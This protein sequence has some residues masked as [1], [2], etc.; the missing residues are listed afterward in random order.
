MNNGAA[1]TLIPAHVVGAKALSLTDP[2]AANEAV[3]NA[4]KNKDK[5]ALKPIADFWNTGFDADQLPSDPSLYLSSG[6]YKVTSY[7]QRANLTLERN[8]DYNWGPIPS[9]DK[10]T[11]SII[12]D[13]TAAVQALTN[14]EIDIISPQATADIYQAVAR[15]QGPRHRGQDR[16][17]RYLRAR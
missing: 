14:E 16:R 10:I 2:A 15:P 11:Y 7:A 8:P 6:P 5:A 3:I 12:G 17:R 1:G 13:P 9:V 4:F